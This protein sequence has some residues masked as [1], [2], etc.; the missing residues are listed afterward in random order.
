MADIDDSATIIDFSANWDEVVFVV[1]DGKR[2]VGGFDVRDR[3]VCSCG[4]E[5]GDGVGG[6]TE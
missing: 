2:A 3:G 4:G 5:G 1:G 6:G